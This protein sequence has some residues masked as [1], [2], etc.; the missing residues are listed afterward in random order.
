MAE[1]SA[2]RKPST[3]VCAPGQTH[4]LIACVKQGT[5]SEQFRRLGKYS[6]QICA[7]G[8]AH[9]CSHQGS[10]TQVRSPVGCLPRTL[11]T[12]FSARFFRSRTALA[13]PRAS[14]G[15]SSARCRSRMKAPTNLCVNFQ[16]CGILCPCAGQAEG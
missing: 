6:I 1:T 14:G 3:E 7:F 12:M 10:E 16:P 5:I 13:L 11:P 9:F 8:C 15:V 2:C 4:G